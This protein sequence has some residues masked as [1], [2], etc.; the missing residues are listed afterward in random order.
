MMKHTTG[1][2][3]QWLAEAVHG[4]SDWVCLAAAPSFAVIALLTGLFGG[5]A[6]AMSCM[7]AHD[8]SP[9]SG[10]TFMYMLMSAFHSAPW[11][12]RISAWGSDAR[13]SWSGIRQI[14]F[15][16]PCCAARQGRSTQ[17]VRRR[18]FDSE[19]PSHLSLS[20]YSTRD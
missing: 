4:A 20:P 16:S 5:G 2:R 12:K 7:G 10:M 9:L 1:M 19:M 15:K 8:A 14:E 18:R 3:E 17:T 11:L 6:Q 13:R